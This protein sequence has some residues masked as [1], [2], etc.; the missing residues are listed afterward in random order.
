M[1]VDI[2]GD[3]I[4]LL[5][6]IVYLVVLYVSKIGIIIGLMFTTEKVCKAIIN[7]NLTFY[8]SKILNGLGIVFL[9]LIIYL[10]LV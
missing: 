8:A 1:A 5:L 2:G 6:D 9:S 4:Q 3:T 7:R 10:V